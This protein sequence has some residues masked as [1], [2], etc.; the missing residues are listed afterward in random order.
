MLLIFVICNFSL[1]CSTCDKLILLFQLVIILVDGPQAEDQVP[2]IPLSKASQPLRDRD[3]AIYAVG[4]LPFTSEE[5]LQDLTSDKAR[6]FLYPVDE[7]PRRTPQVLHQWFDTW[8]TRWRPKGN[9][10]MFYDIQ[11]FNIYHIP[12]SNGNLHGFIVLTRK[13]NFVFVTELHACVTTSCH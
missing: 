1:A 2:Y 3:I 4:A 13:G 12:I 9:E 6:V 11:L 5:E 7:L 8:L 10:A